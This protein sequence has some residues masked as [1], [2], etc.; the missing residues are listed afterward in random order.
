MELYDVKLVEKYGAFAIEKQLFFAN[1]VGERNWNVDVQKGEIYFG[2]DLVFPIQIIGTFAHSSETW[3]WAWAN[4]ESGIPE[5]LLGHAKKLKEYGTVHKI[6][7]LTEDQFEI[8]RDD[9]HYIGMIALGITGS[10]GYYLGNYGAGTLCV[11]INTEEI[12]EKFPNDHVSIFTAFPQL[13]SRFEINHKEAFVNYL[14]T[15]KYDVKR[16]E[17]EV[18]GV[19]GENKVE[20]IFDRLGRLIKLNSSSA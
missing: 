10:N 1:I 7:F 19:C 11:T 3:L 8:E 12:G 9:M 18:V 17:N 15:K 16:N 2:E 13:I 14:N 20:A 6:D 5:K 4:S